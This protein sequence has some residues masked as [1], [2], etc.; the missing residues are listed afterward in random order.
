MQKCE[1]FLEKSE[2]K[3]IEISFDQMEH[4]AGNMLEVKNKAGKRFLVMSK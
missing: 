4:F 1:K 2:K 3:I